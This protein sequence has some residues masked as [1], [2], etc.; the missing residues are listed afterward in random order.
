MGWGCLTLKLPFYLVTFLYIFISCI[1]LVPWTLKGQEPLCV[2]Q[3]AVT[4]ETG[5][6]LWRMPQTSVSPQPAAKCRS[7]P[8]WPRLHSEGTD[9]DVHLWPELPHLWDRVGLGTGQRV[10]VTRWTERARLPGECRFQ[11]RRWGLPAPGKCQLIASGKIQRSLWM[12]RC[13]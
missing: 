4:G 10:C 5:S 11:T 12:C 2:A 6:V 8:H 9:G 13:P 7:A 3:P 1:L